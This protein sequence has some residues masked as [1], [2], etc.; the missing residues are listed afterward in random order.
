MKT[1]SLKDHVYTNFWISRRFNLLRTSLNLE[2]NIIVRIDLS[3]LSMIKQRD[4]QSIHFNYTEI[5]I[6]C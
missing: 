3:H 1:K 2:H 4:Q 6:S 5:Y